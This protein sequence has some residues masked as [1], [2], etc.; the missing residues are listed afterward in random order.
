MLEA[1][2]SIIG[3]FKKDAVCCIRESGKKRAVKNMATLKSCKW[4]LTHG[5]SQQTSKVTYDQA[6]WQILALSNTLF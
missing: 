4:L 1:K 5:T 3:L 6:M 2:K